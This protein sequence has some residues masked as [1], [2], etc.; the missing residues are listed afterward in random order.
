MAGKHRIVFLVPSLAQARRAILTA[1]SCGI[2]DKDVHLIARPDI[3]AV[4]VQDTRKIADR[5]LVPAA[6]RGIGIGAVIGLLVA[7]GLWVVGMAQ[8]MAWWVFGIAIGAAVGGFGAALEGASVTDPIRKHF[9]REIA[10]GNV[11]VVVDA[12]PDMLARLQPVMEDDGAKRQPY[13][14]S[15]A[16]S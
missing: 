4:R 14:A 13:D 8:S 3:E 2:Q 12:E 6:L 15:V 11:L 10:A 16:L 5:D 9:E 1:V 7:T